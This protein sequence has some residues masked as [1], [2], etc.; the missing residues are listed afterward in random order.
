[1]KKFQRPKP[2]T[3]RRQP[4]MLSYGCI[5]HYEQFFENQNAAALR[6]AKEKGDG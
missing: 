3:D 4:P 1:M 5:L 2:T 6:A